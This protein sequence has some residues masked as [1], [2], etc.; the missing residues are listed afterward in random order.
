MAEYIAQVGWRGVTAATRFCHTPYRAPMAI[1]DAADRLRPWANFK[2]LWTVQTMA[3]SPRTFSEATQQEL[4]EAAC[5]FD[6][7]E[8]RL[9]QLLA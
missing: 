4:A 9:G 2:R 6:L 7:P 1:G 3:H 5:L 8:H